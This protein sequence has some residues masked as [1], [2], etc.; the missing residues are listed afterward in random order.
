MNNQMTTT[1]GELMSAPHMAPPMTLVELSGQIRLVQ[2][3]MH[4]VMQDGTHYGIVPGCGDKRVL[5]QPGA[6]KLSM[7]FRLCP[8]FDIQCNDLPGS[9]KEYQVICTLKSMGSDTFVGQ[10]VGACS[11]MESKYRWRKGARKCPECGREAIIKGK[12]EFGGGWLCWQKKDGCGA[13]WPDGAPEIENQSVDRVENPDPADVWNTCL[14]I[15]K[16]RAHVDAVMT[17]LSVSDIFTQDLGDEE[18]H[19]DDPVQPLHQPASSQQDDAEQAVKRWTDRL[20]IAA[21]QGTATLAAIWAQL[22]ATPGAQAYFA[23]IKGRLKA[24]AIQADQQQRQPGDEPE[25][26]P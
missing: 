1:D 25:E 26:V 23:P 21:M 14:K 16:K 9:H 7:T 12:A 17:A 2:N 5:L 18:Q 4:E 13:K 24:T 3:V 8:S 10:G 15:A 19:I 20:E 22:K 6:Q 11:T